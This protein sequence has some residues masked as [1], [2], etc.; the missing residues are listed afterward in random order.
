[1]KLL[2]PFTYADNVPPPAV[3]NPDPAPATTFAPCPASGP[4]PT[5]TAA[6]PDEPGTLESG[7]SAGGL[8]AASGSLTGARLDSSVRQLSAAG[9]DG[10]ARQ[11]SGASRSQLTSAGG[12]CA[13][14]LQPLEQ[15][16]GAEEAAPAAATEP[17][18]VAVVQERAADPDAGAEAG[19]EA[20]DQIIVGAAP[21]EAPSGSLSSE[22]SGSPA[23]SAN[24]ASSSPPRLSV[25][26]LMQARE[27]ER[28][29][30]AAADAAPT[31]SNSAVRQ[32]PRRS[33][34]MGQ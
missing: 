17:S 24:Q 34:V 8:S 32:W 26:Q 19:A 2:S 1:M 14:P 27:R 20:G 9:L 4:A 33:A 21:A 7:S 18:S 11:L 13:S 5:T 23:S 6:T 30:A 10:S 15:G 31:G 22:G 29:A 16:A 3:V 28:Q 25:W 12:R